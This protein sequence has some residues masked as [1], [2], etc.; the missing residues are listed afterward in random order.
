M[1]ENRV[2]GLL[3]LMEMRL[4][5]HRKK[6]FDGKEESLSDLIDSLNGYMGIINKEVNGE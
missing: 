2:Y 1:S 4:E 6:F 5:E 3:S